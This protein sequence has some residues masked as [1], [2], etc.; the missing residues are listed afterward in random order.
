MAIY[1]K[2]TLFAEGARGSCSEELIN[3]FKL[4]QAKTELNTT[5]NKST[6]GHGNK[7]EPQTYG[8]G[9]KEVWEIDPSK[10]K[11]GSVTHTIGWPAQDGTYQGTFMYHADN[12]QVYI[13][14]VTG[15]DYENPY[16]SPYQEFQKFKTHPSVKAVLE[17][18][19]CLGRLSIIIINNNNRFISFV[20]IVNYI[21]Y[22]L[23]LL[24]LILLKLILNLIMY[25][26]V[27]YL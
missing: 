13:G 24:L 25:L 16:V 21:H 7:C 15:L 20:F 27:I 9:L 26:F 17:G 2:Q 4:R 10:H 18:G 23:L 6:L 19:K 3:K 12:N 5:T 14:L 8:I 1:G 11:K 22:Y